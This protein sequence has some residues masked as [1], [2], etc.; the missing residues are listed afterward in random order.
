MCEKENPNYELSQPFDVLFHVN[1]NSLLTNHK[2]YSR[3]RFFSKTIKYFLESVF[4]IG[5][6]CLYACVF[7]FYMNKQ[8]RQF[9]TI[10]KRLLLFIHSKRFQNK[11]CRNS[12]VLTTHYS[13]CELFTLLYQQK[14]LLVIHGVSFDLNG[15][16]F[17]RFLIYFLV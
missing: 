9:Y 4:F 3:L 5:Y 2:V 14:L 13:Y 17:E 12:L 16:I 11:T 8:H 10:V 7:L 6:I 15:F 1:Q